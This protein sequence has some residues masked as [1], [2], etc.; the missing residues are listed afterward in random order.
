MPCNETADCT[1]KICADLQGAYSTQPRSTFHTRKHAPQPNTKQQ[2]EPISE[3]QS[4]QAHQQEYKE[5]AKGSSALAV[6]GATM[7]AHTRAMTIRVSHHIRHPH[8]AVVVYQPQM[9]L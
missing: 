4:V 6:V 3:T 1:P 7:R 5:L 8:T 9:A 2:E